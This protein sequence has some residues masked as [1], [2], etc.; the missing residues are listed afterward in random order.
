MW[1]VF[2]N[3]GDA[4]VTLPI[5]AVCACWIAL[6]DV[7]LAC[8][9]IATLA[10]GVAVVGASK[11]VYAGWGISFPASDF[12]VI[13]GHA[14]LSTSVWIVAITLQ[15]K[16]W[17]LPPSIGIVAGLAIGALT[18][19]SRVM[20]HSHS[21]PEVVSGWILGALVAMSFLRAALS[22]EFDRLRPAWS[23]A[24]LLFVSALA[25]GHHAP[26]QRLIETRSPEIHSHAHSIMAYVGRVR[27][28]VQ[29]YEGTL[30]R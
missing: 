9:W 14:M 16:W 13:S 28:R 8:R 2:T 19:V 11:I 24:S 12:R 6:F 22:V 21:L 17:R 23:T 4:A 27:Y 1:T 30:A 20:D 7:R 26:L 10:A 29:S 18:G 5:A 3:L 15:L 25:Y